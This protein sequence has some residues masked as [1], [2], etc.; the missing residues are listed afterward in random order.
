M[1][2]KTISH[3]QIKKKNPF[4]KSIFL[5]WSFN[6]QL[7]GIKKFANH[8]SKSHIDVLFYFFAIQKSFINCNQLWVNGK[9]GQKNI[10]TLVVTYTNKLKYL[11]IHIFIYKIIVEVP[12]CNI[13]TTHTRT[14][15][16]NNILTHTITFILSFHYPVTFLYTH[17][18]IH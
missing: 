6:R 8:C 13:N 7:K 12:I 14:W 4:L 9:K 15:F 10:Y 11:H 1:Y 3:I 18:Y 17:T 2:Q 5:N 16:P